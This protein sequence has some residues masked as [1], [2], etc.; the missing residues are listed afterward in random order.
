MPHIQ[1]QD[2]YTELQFPPTL[3][4]YVSPDNPVRFID[5]F[6][7]QLDLAALGFARVTAAVEGRPGYAPGDLLKLYLYGYLNRIRSSRALERETHRNVELMWLIKQL[8]PGHKTIADFR[9]VHSAALRGVCREF[10]K[11]CKEWELFGGE[12]I[13]V[14]G[15]KFLAVNRR[16]RNFTSDKLKKLLKE[17]DEQIERYLKDLEQQDA[18][19]V[20][21]TEQT[22]RLRQKLERL[23]ERK[24]KQE[25]I[26]T[27]MIAL[28]QTQISLTD[29][30]SRYMVKGTDTI[31]GYNVQTAV[32]AKHK[33]IVAHEV[34]NDVIDQL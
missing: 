3:D 7:D 31:I 10:T 14:D 22:E 8:R 32:D 12:L 28:G 26:Q 23:K 27:E 17:A 24:A 29:P 21:A 16:Q 6:V 2:R 18:A 1:G 34:T 5:A 11:L 4:E 30:D 33:L 19:A 15:S 13:A 9:K 20:N 25:A